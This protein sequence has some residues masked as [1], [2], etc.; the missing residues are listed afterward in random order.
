M[1]LKHPNAAE[2]KPLSPEGRG[3]GFGDGGLNRGG[4]L[5][6]GGDVFGLGVEGVGDMCGFVDGGDVAVFG[7]APDE[8]VG[9]AVRMTLGS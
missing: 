5:R 9:G 6:V 8:S 4:F 2:H 1:Q 3:K 7:G